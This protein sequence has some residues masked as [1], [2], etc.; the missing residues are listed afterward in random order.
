MIV[1]GRLIIFI[2]HIAIG[3]GFALALMVIFSPVFEKSALAQALG[4]EKIPVIVYHDVL[5]FVDS[6]DT[7]NTSVIPLKNFA[8]QMEYLHSNGYNTASLSD[9]R[10]FVK[11]KKKLP[12]RTVVITFDDGYESNYIHCYPYL[13]KYNFRAAVFLMG[14]V[15]PNARPHL[16]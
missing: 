4:T 16:T 1:R 3:M 12:P 2:G 10:D 8:E 9:L 6:Q 5:P 14:S 11:G 15:P 13:K 7:Y